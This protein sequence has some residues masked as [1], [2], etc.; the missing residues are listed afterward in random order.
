[1]FAAI[2]H[3]GGEHAFGKAIDAAGKAASGVAWRHVPRGA[4][5]RFLLRVCPAQFL[6]N[7][8]P[9]GWCGLVVVAM[10]LMLLP[11]LYLDKFHLQ[12]VEQDG[13]YEMLL[14]GSFRR[15]SLAPELQQDFERHTEEYWR[16]LTP[17]HHHDPQAFYATLVDALRAR[18]LGRPCLD[19]AIDKMVQRLDLDSLWLEFGVWMGRSLNALSRRSIELG[20]SR[21]VYGFDSFKGLP[22]TWRNNKSGA[23]LGDEWA[24]RWTMKGAFNL[25]G[26]PPEYF[27]DQRGADFV[28]G[29]FN[30]S[31]PPFLAREAGPVTLVH[32]DSDLYSSAALVLRLIAPRLRSGTILI[33]DELINYPG[34]KEGEARALFEWIH[35]P[36]FHDAGL[37]GVQVIGYRGPEIIEDD[38]AL[39]RAI[40]TQRSEGRRY[41]QDA[42]FVVW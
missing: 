34:Y 35:S 27:V 10:L 24:K 19:Y 28:V 7:I 33:F 38:K 15:E 13:S 25:G 4:A 1:M 30:E 39:A 3:A 6:A 9:R 21:K 8:G 40:K 37:T 22:E 29:W 14:P 16:L 17:S 32:I 26:Q 36:E 5:R 11:L 31:L 41:P 18:P 2:P 12:V 42:L 20:R 23:V